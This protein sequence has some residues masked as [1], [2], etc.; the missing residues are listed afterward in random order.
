MA[1]GWAIIAILMAGMIWLVWTY[2]NVPIRDGVRWLRY[3]QMYIMS[4]F[5]SRD[6]MIHFNGQDVPWWAGFQDTP[7]WKAEQ[8]TYA[9][10]AYFN[11]LALR[12]IRYLLSAVVVCMGFFALFRGPKTGFRQKLDL[13]HL[14]KRQSEVFP[15]IKPFADFNPSTLP[16]RPPGSPVPAELPAFAE[17]LGPEEWLAYNNIPAPNGTID[18]AAVTAAFE[19]QLGGRWRGWQAL[20]P[21]KQ[22]LLAAFCLKAARK[23]KDCDALLGQLAECWTHKKGLKLTRKIL[24]EART[25]LRDKKLA[26]K[27]IAQINRHGFETT[28]ILRALMFARDEGGVLAPAQFVWLRAYDRALW[29]PLNNLG[30]KSFHTEALGAMCHFKAERLTQRPIPVA[31]VGDAATTMRDYMAT[32]RARPIPQ[33]DYSGSEKKAIKKVAT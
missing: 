28:A 3:G 23:R 5:I 6:Y 25:V 1:V 16:A 32:S 30:R 7:K 11:V 31:K 19:K 22:V 15:V 9:H 2:M 24:K 33:L 4:F 10:L 20:A 12:P 29:Y 13:E 17:A 8:L 21:Y 18:M 14:I 27:T 26:D